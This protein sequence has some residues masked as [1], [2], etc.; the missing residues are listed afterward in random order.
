MEKP[1]KKNKPGFNLKK[2]LSFK[3]DLSLKWKLF[4]YLL[5]FSAILLIILWLFQI[6]FLDEFY[7]QVKTSE[8]RKTVAEAEAHIEGPLYSGEDSELPA[9][10]ELSYMETLS[11]MQAVVRERDLD[12]E[13]VDS[14]GNTLFSAQGTREPILSRISALDK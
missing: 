7:R 9:V 8:L 5:S 12:I 13:I 10:G 6:A 1:Q 11:D 2:G 14:S 4:M 3:N